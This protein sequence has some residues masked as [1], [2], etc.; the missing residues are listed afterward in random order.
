MLRLVRGW[1]KMG[2]V[3]DQSPGYGAELIIECAN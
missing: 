1:R 3:V 2:E